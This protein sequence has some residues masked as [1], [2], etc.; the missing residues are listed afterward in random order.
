MGMRISSHSAGSRTSAHASV[1]ATDPFRKH[2]AALKKLPRRAGGSQGDECFVS[3]T[4][5]YYFA[6]SYDGDQERLLIENLTNEIYRSLGV[7]VPDT[8]LR[9][10]GGK[11][12]LLS[13]DVKGRTVP[14]DALR[15]AG[16]S[17]HFVI[18]AWLANWDVVGLK[19]DNIVVS[20]VKEVCSDFLS[21]R[22]P[23]GTAFRVNNGGSLYMRATGDKKPFTQEVSELD[24]MRDPGSPAG[25]VFGNLTDA[26][27]AGQIRVFLAQYAKHHEGVAERIRH[28]GLPAATRSKLHATLDARA[29]WLANVALP[30]FQR[31]AVNAFGGDENKAM[32]AELRVLKEDIWDGDVDEVRHNWPRAPF[33]DGERVALRSYMRSDFR[34]IN[35]ALRGEAPGFSHW[36]PAGERRKV[37]VEAYRGYID[38]MTSALSKL[39]DFRGEVTRVTALTRGQVARYTKG[40]VVTEHAFTSTSEHGNC[41]YD[42]NVV[43]DIQS[44]HGKRILKVNDSD[45]REVLFAPGV[46]FKVLDKKLDPEDELLHIKLR[47]V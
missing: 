18:D 12:Y 11:P 22:Y 8:Y 24:T 47:E 31:A 20:G 15:R 6:K 9:R 42:G 21:K 28:S 4:R 14:P 26:E 30:R 23:K 29:R 34:E 10:I 16:I 25:K 37:Q 7:P 19:H 45:E 46:R 36:V 17:R 13:A 2:P 43:F 1:R 5:E 41:P 3:K 27:I 38:L 32:E 40:K 33:S 39:R 44:K 35:E